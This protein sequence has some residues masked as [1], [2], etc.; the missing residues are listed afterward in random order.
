[1]KI[2]KNGAIVRFETKDFSKTHFIKK[3]FHYLIQWITGSNSHHVGI[4]CNGYLYEALGSTGVRKIKL[5]D[6]KEDKHI[7]IKIEN[8]L[9]PLDKEE[10]NRLEAFLN[11]QIGKK[12]GFIEAFLSILTAIVFLDSDEIKTKTH[13]CS[14][15]VVYAIKTIRPKYLYDIKPRQLNP[16]EAL[17]ILRKVGYI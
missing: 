5:E 12:Y 16:E 11:R 6:R 3:P 14:K 2:I 10:V 7:E 13:F 17:K 4:W 9:F 8:P 1:M 15:L